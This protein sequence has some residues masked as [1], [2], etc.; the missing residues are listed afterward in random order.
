MG[1]SKNK[2]RQ[3]LFPVAIHKPIKEWI[4]LRDG[5]FVSLEDWYIVPATPSTVIEWV[6]TN[7]VY[8][9]EQVK[10]PATEGHDRMCIYFP[11]RRRETF[12]MDVENGEIT[13]E[14]VGKTFLIVGE[15]QHINYATKAD[16]WGQFRLEQV[17]T[18]TRGEF[19]YY[20]D[21]SLSPQGPKGEDGDT[22]TFT[23]KP[24]QT[25]PVGSDANL[26]VDQE[27]NNYDLTFQIPAGA[28]G[29]PGANGEPGEKWDD[30]DTIDLRIGQ[31]TGGGTAAANIRTVTPTMRELDLTIPKGE[32]GEDGLSPTPRN[33][34]SSAYAYDYLDI[35]RYPD[36]D[37]VGCSWIRKDKT[38]QAGSWDV[39]GESDGWML[40]N[41]DGE[42][43]Q[44]GQDG[45]TVVVPVEWRP[46]KDWAP[47]APGE[48]GNDGISPHNEWNWNA[49]TPYTELAMV[50]ASTGEYDPW[51]NEIF[52]YYIT[53]GWVPAWDDAPKDNPYWQ[54]L[55]KDGMA[56][57]GNIWSA[58]V[59]IAQDQR[60]NDTFDSW[61]NGHWQKVTFTHCTW[62]HDMVTT[63]WITITKT[64]H[65]RVYWHAIIENNVDVSNM[66]INLWRA[67]IQLVTWRNGWV[68]TFWLA[69]AKQG[70]PYATTQG[71]WLD[72]TVDC[73]V[74]LYEWDQLSLW[75]RA[76]TDTTSASWITIDWAPCV[77]EFKGALDD[78][79]SVPA[80]Y[81][82]WYFA[83]YLGVTFISKTTPQAW[84]AAKFIQTI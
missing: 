78:S 81:V 50:R 67:S 74:D 17:I 77:F 84:I 43:W 39:P 18:P 56:G 72:L 32:D 37:G 19:T 10:E 82:G 49:N 3:T 14:D 44:P 1:A 54:L 16:L 53:Q 40:L 52:G 73:E 36:Q 68:T 69:T 46:G 60:K 55:S 6:A 62:N 34:W 80:G 29:R 57:D 51:G 41:M 64:W 47:G 58:M 48:K 26:I 45:G 33:Q 5:L 25:L 61:G 15:L 35:V 2:T 13:Q 22:P 12:T 30:W 79:G 42:E 71:P 20:F 11:K 65:Y 31:V 23:F 70:G 24:V 9:K 21:S 59:F 83:T 8:N 4:E 63:N 38:R 75:Y 27:G 28:N 66:L 7:D 76:Q